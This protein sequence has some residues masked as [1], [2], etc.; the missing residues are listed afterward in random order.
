[1]LALD[2]LLSRRLPDYQPQKHL[3]GSV[4]FYLRG[5]GDHFTKND[6]NTDPDA[7]VCFTPINVEVL[8]QWRH[9]VLPD[10]ENEGDS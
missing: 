6:H 4:Y 8:R 5:M 2:Q 9:S 7:G 10:T 3:G 1:M